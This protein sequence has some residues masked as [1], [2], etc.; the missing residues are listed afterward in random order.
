MSPFPRIRALRPWLAAG[1]RRAEREALAEIRT[2]LSRDT[3]KPFELVKNFTFVSLVVIFIGTLLLSMIITHRARTVLLQK[4]EAYAL[5]LAN[6][7]N[8]QIFHKFVLPTALQFGRIRL[9]NEVQYDRMDRVIKST[10]H[11]FNVDRVSL[12]DTENVVSYSFDPDLV[13]K[14][15]AGGLEYVQALEGRTTSR[16][17]QS[18]SFFAILMGIPDESR[19]RTF[20]PLFAEKPL[21]DV[22]GHLLGVVEITQDL[23]AD[24][25]TIF[26]FQLLIVAS[27]AGIMGLLFLILRFYVQRGE[28][29]LWRRAEERLKLEE[30]LSRAERLASL[31]EMTAG[32]SHE[33]RNPLGIIRST[34]ELLQKRAGDKD[35]AATRLTDVIIEESTRLNNII[36]DFLDFARPPVPRMAE[37]R[38][39][40]VL[41]KTLVHLAPRLDEEGHRVTVHHHG[42]T[43]GI[44]ADANQVHQCLLNV[45][46]NAMQAMP[47][48]GDMVVDLFSDGDSLEVSVTDSGPG[49]DEANLKKIFNP[50]FTTKE[51]GTGLGLCV[52]RNV[53][54]AHGG[55]VWME[56]SPAG[57]ARVRIK[58]PMTSHGND[59]NR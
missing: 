1:R 53:V 11:G 35:P 20:S 7:L 41:K 44:Q 55:R 8:H 36:T 13:G 15:G 32:V 10:L 56:N 54:E 40:E 47:G 37:T 21:E 27:S 50:F 48:G 38:V 30:Q 2:T 33:I 59:L 16:L 12:Y 57:G 14:E 25:R 3:V 4:S 9:S 45:F 24:Y 43:P 42:E 58:L 52:V 34:A 5:L 19:L 31:G 46:I 51:R 39:E 28:A 26:W 49:V 29:I 17:I 22:S 23:S 18:G 6:N